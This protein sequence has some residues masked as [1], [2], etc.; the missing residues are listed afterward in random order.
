[1]DGEKILLL[2]L[3]YLKGFG[4]PGGIIQAG[5]TAEQTLRREILEETGLAVETAKYLFS[6]PS[7][8][9]GI[10]TLSLVYEV[11]ATGNLKQ[12]REGSLHWLKP[13]DV[14]QRM[15]YKSGEQALK[16]YLSEKFV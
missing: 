12:S 7:S 11:E 5:E 2:S 9:A 13:A 3:S 4:L 14:M 10:S 1:M 6:V 8:I 16:V 15:A